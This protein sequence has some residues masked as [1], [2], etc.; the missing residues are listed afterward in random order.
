VADPKTIL[1]PPTAMSSHSAKVASAIAFYF[2]V[3]I[4]LVF[5]NKVRRPAGAAARSRVTRP[6]R[7][8]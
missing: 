5:L 8:L 3:S 7:R 2:T 6:A 1:Q 4:S